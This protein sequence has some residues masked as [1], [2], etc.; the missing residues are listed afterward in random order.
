MMATDFLAADCEYRK[1]TSWLLQNFNIAAEDFA[2]ISA[3][4]GN[5]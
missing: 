4:Y 1:K 2:V 3:T 5:R